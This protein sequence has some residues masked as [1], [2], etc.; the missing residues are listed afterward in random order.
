M[1]QIAKFFFQMISKIYEFGASITFELFGY[2]VSVFSLIAGFTIITMILSFFHLFIPSNNVGL[3][4]IGMGRNENR[5]D[6]IQQ[7]RELKA[8]R[9]GA[10]HAKNTSVPV[11]TNVYQRAKSRSSN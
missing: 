8:I 11:H 6:R 10:R 2:N 3:S 9:S 4:R 1:T 5:H 7:Q